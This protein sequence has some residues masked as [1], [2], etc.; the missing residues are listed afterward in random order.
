MPFADANGQRLYYE[1]HGEGEPLL[2]VMG[3]GAD[4]FA[5]ALQVGPLSEHF[6]VVTFDNRDVGQ[7]SYANGPYEITDLAADTIALADALELDRFHLLGASMGGCVAQELALGWPD[8]VRTLT[9]AITYGGAGAW[10]RKRGRLSA[11]DVHHRSWEEHID[12]MMLL[13]FSEKLYEETERITL[14]RQQ[15]LTNP[16][17]Q[18]PEGFARQAEASGRH[19]ARERLPSLSIPVHVVGAERDYLV[20]VW[21]SRE[22]AE[23]VPGAKLTIIEDA[24]HGLNLERAEEFNA[25]VLDFLRS[26]QPSAA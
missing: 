18:A 22:L 20:P 23:L 21:K 1:L 15:M 6:R 8:R 12:N 19:E 5:W 17:P 26:A 13:S 25:A 11:A 9:L 16:Y 24:A 2:M 10:G 7:S 14:L 3:L 4:H